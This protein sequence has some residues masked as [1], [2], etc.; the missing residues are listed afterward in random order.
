M[1]MPIYC[2]S[3]LPS[4]CTT[5][6]AMRMMATPACPLLSMVRLP[7]LST[8][9]VLMSVEATCSRDSWMMRI[10]EYSYLPSV[11]LENNCLA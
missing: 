3:L 5:T 1:T 4:A 2:T 8:I 6:I 11:T 10:W 9:S 7:T